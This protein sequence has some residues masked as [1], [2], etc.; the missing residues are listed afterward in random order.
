[1]LPEVR[2]LK[3]AAD[4]DVELTDE[5]VSACPGL[6]V[7]DSSG[8]LAVGV[9]RDHENV[10]EKLRTMLARDE[11]SEAAQL[12]KRKD[13]CIFT[14]ESTGVLSPQELLVQAVDIL[15]DKAQRLADKL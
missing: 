2:L 15:H 3:D 9:A 7:R 11:I 12:R 14:I 6:F 8:L 13:H 4:I 1:M 10:L 5:L